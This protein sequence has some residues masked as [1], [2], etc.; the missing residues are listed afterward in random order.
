MQMLEDLRDLILAAA[1]GLNVSVILLNV[2]AQVYN[3]YNE[4]Y[5]NQIILNLLAG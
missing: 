3:S 1:T 4:L 5:L 2:A